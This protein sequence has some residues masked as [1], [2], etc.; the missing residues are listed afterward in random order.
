[1]Y[2]KLVLFVIHKEKQKEARE[3]MTLFFS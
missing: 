1:M 2:Y 3:L